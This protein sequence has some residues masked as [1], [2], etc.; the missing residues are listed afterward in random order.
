VGSFE[1]ESAVLLPL[2]IPANFWNIC[3]SISFSERTL[4]LCALAALCE[5]QKQWFGHHDA[6]TGASFVTAS[7][8]NISFLL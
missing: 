2:K 1:H 4:E 5:N 8:K 3:A 6:V 7:R